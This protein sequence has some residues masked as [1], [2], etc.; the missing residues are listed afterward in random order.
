MNNTEKTKMLDFKNLAN[1]EIE[2]TVIQYKEKVAE[3]PKI[4]TKKRKILPE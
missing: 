4:D 1:P 3:I 2:S